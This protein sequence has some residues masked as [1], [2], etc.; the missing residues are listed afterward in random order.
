MSVGADARHQGGSK[1]EPQDRGVFKIA[2]EYGLADVITKLETLSC[3][4]VR[5]GRA[6]REITIQ[7]AC[8]LPQR[9]FLKKGPLRGVSDSDAKRKDRGLRF[10]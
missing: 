6:R 2:I 4:C 8:H 1:R 5:L 3:G 10:E 7:P 9:V